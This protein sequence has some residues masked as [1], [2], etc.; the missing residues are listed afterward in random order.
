[1]QLEEYSA[2]VVLQGSNATFIKGA[3]KG[4]VWVEN[5]SSLAT[6]AKINPLAQRRARFA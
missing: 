4:M 6:R 3:G 5:V 2:R 1:M